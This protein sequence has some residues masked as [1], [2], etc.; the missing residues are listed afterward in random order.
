MTNTQ[1]VFCNWGKVSLCLQVTWKE[2]KK[3]EPGNQAN[4]PSNKSEWTL[5]CISIPVLENLRMAL[6][7]AE[8]M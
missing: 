2:L 7:Q 8:E 5:E 4:Q 3:Y 1:N 6:E